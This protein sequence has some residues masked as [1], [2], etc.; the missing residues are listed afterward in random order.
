[1][2]D[3]LSGNHREFFD[4]D[5]GIQPEV[6]AAAEEALGAVESLSRPVAG[7]DEDS[8]ALVA[9]VARQRHTALD[10]ARNVH[11]ATIYAG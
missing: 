11:R 10:I 1:M 5:S 8:G 3:H 2:I 9:T 7:S 4:P 6:L